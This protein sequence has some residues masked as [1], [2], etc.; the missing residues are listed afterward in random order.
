[1]KKGFFLILEGCEGTGKSTV[2]HWLEE[3]LKEKGY[4]VF[5]TREPGGKGSPVA[6][7]IRE[8]I[9]NKEN[10]V[11]P[12]TEAYLF[13]ASRAQHVNEIIIP[14]LKNH[15][16]VICDRFVY[17]SYAYQGGGRNLGLEKIKTIN[18]FAIENIKPDLILLFDLDP[19]IGLERKYQNR[20]D[21]D[22]L[23]NE[24]LE[25]H[26]RVRETY[27]QLAREAPELIKIVNVNKPLEEVKQIA[28]TIVN[29]KLEEINYGQH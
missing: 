8:I 15:E 2:G 16:I 23:D 11:L 19:K 13:A 7:K 28:L 6:E 18:S 24:N 1:M 17:S 4:P 9:L 26:I 20:Q 3:K 21:L 14:H 25:F 22:R 29:Q 10:N 27:L 5:F 12:L